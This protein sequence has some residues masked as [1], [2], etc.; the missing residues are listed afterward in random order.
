MSNFKVGAFAV[1]LVSS[2]IMEARKLLE[3]KLWDQVA[4]LNSTAIEK[5][6]NLLSKDFKSFQEEDLIEEFPDRLQFFTLHWMI[7]RLEDTESDPY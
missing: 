3:R 2:T 4:E 6:N 5:M 7:L 1:L